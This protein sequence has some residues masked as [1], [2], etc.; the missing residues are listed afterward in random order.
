LEKQ[1]GKTGGQAKDK[2]L[3][4]KKNTVKIP[5]GLSEKSGLCLLQEFLASLPPG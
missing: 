3:P 1:E 2:A 5:E 4:I